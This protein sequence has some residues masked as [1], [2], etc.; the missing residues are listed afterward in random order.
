MFCFVQEVR[1]TAVVNVIVRTCIKFLVTV[2]F[3]VVEKAIQNLKLL[4][5]LEVSKSTL[6]FFISSRADE[7]NSRIVGRSLIHSWLS[8]Y[9]V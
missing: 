4:V 1:V 6:V 9:Y 8:V 2:E 7:C 5:L 3:L